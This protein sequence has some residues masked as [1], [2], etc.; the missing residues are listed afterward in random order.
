MTTVVHID[1][2]GAMTQVAVTRNADEPLRRCM[3]R[4]KI[5]RA[6]V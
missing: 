1:T 2:F 3:K 5:G 6:H 4:V